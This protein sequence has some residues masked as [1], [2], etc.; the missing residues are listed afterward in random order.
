MISFLRGT[1]LGRE[2]DILLLETAG[3]V[4]YDI[5]MKP[6][7]VLAYAVGGQ[8]TIHTYLKVSENSLELYGFTTLPERSFFL[9]LLTVTGVGPK[10]ALHI[11]SLGPL[12]DIQAAI[13]RGDAAY[14]TSVSGIGK[15]TAERLVVELK[16]KVFSQKSKVGDGSGGTLGEVVQGLEALGYSREEAKSAIEGLESVGKSTEELLRMALKRV[17]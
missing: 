3:G 6:V 14:L 2:K 7:D 10:T 9:L 4:G 8:A 12:T 16:S 13:A 17:T 1:V 11:L 5:R 15:K